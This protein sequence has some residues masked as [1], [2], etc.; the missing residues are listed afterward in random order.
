MNERQVGE[1]YAEKLASVEKN[2]KEHTFLDNYGIRYL[3]KLKNKL[4]DGN[5]WIRPTTTKEGTIYSLFSDFD[6]LD[7]QG[8]TRKYRIETSLEELE[9]LEER[10]EQ[11]FS[12]NYDEIELI[13]I[14][15]SEFDDHSLTTSNLR[16]KEQTPTEKPFNNAFGSLSNLN[17]R[18]EKDYRRKYDRK[19]LIEEY[20]SETYEINEE[21]DFLIRNPSLD[22]EN[23]P[24]KK[25][26]YN[27]FENIEE[28]R[29]EANLE[30]IAGLGDEFKETE[31]LLETVY[32]FE[33]DPVKE[34]RTP[35][36][37]P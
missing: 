16:R 15:K 19:I 27:H 26:F 2:S 20:L 34:L 1:K 29:V 17:W 7:N 25:V 28:L 4:S 23:L 37:N 6:V 22:S 18:L 32:S 8:F 9:I 14:A 13:G 30:T 10:I 5:N 35:N 36:L 24:P 33:E 21:F 3:N 12:R 31:E 11:H